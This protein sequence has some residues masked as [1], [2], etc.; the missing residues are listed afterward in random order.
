MGA[1]VA[2]DTQSSTALQK[3]DWG[4]GSR[5]ALSMSRGRE[6]RLPPPFY[7]AWPEYEVEKKKPKFMDKPL[8]NFDLENWCEYLN[9]PVKGIFSWNQRIKSNHSPCIINMNDYGSLGTHWVCCNHEKARK[10]LTHLVFLHQMKGTKALVAR[11]SRLSRGMTIKYK[12]STQ[13][14]VVITACYS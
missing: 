6:Q 1:A 2:G 10:I 9:I 3:T 14:D 13:S 12:S 11:A 4:W 5:C 7:G 8:S